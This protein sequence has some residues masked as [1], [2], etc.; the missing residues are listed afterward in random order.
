MPCTWCNG[1]TRRIA[2]SAVHSH[3]VINDVT[4]ARRFACVVTTPLG[5]P[6]VPLV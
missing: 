4:C 5:F 2:S 1:S 6:V 3:A